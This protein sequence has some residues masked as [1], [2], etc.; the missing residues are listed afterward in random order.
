M[1]RRQR[2]KLQAFWNTVAQ[3]LTPRS[4]FPFP[5]DVG[6]AHANSL[7][8]PMSNGVAMRANLV[9]SVRFETAVRTKNFDNTEF[10]SS[11]SMNAILVSI[12]PQRDGAS[13]TMSSRSVW[14]TFRN[15]PV[16][17]GGPWPAHDQLAHHCA[18]VHGCARLGA[19]VR[20]SSAQQVQVNRRECD[21]TPHKRPLRASQPIHNRARISPSL[22]TQVCAAAA[23]HAVC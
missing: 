10:K 22:P 18:V 6:S 19:V 17:H 23:R 20:W 3:L 5:E 4:D 1:R 9:P 21:I 2:T 15:F 12:C 14:P 11:I 7:K 16:R 8:T 13:K